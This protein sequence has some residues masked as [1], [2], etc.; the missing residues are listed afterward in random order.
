MGTEVT[1]VVVCNVSGG[2]ATYRLHH[3]ANGAVYD[4]TN[5]VR[6]DVSVPV[7]EFS[8]FVAESE[9]AGLQME[10]GDSIGGQISAANA[11]TI[12][13]YGVTERVA[14]EQTWQR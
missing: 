4:A 2:A 1:R 14:E 8:D 13:I 6:W 3:D 7:G 11:L 9:G 10:A 12:S 5:A